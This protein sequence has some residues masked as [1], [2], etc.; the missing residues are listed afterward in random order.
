MQLRDEDAAADTDGSL[1]DVMLPSASCVTKSIF[2]REV[3]QMNVFICFQQLPL[4]G[5]C[6]HSV[7]FCAEFLNAGSSENSPHSQLRYQRQSRDRKTAPSL[8]DVFMD[9]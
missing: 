6:F 4:L 3:D 5:F 7:I 9:V 1:G 8:T 2:K